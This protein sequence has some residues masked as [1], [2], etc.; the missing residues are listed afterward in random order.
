[1]S[2]STLRSRTAG[3]T[4]RPQHASHASHASEASISSTASSS[5]LAGRG[6]SDHV[7]GTTAVEGGR[8]EA[9]EQ[10]GDTDRREAWTL[11]APL[12]AVKGT[13]GGINSP[14]RRHLHS[15]SL[16]TFR[17]DSPVPYPPSMP[18][19][20]T[21]PPRSGRSDP[22]EGGEDDDGQQDQEGSP[23]PAPNRTVFNPNA[24]VFRADPTVKSCFDSLMLDKAAE[25]KALFN[26]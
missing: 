6:G 10:K 11:H 2:S 13:F 15:P 8:E 26:A 14:G 16:N 25:L 21:N 20:P 3:S 24:P 1:M 5:T 22:S 19:T 12:P 9:S 23:A 18:A 4:V 7:S 17:A